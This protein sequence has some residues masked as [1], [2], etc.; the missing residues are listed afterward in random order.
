MDLFKANPVPPPV[1]PTGVNRSWDASIAAALFVALLLVFHGLAQDTTYGDG[2]PMLVVFAREGAYRVLWQHVLHFPVGFALRWLGVGDTAFESLRAVSVVSGAAGAALAYILF[3]A[4]RCSR[5]A[6]LG[7]SLLLALSPA[8]VFYSTTIEVHALHA[9][10]FAFAAC[11]VVLA[12]WQ[13][14]WLAAALSALALPL[15][16]LS[17]QSGPILGA[18]LLAMV[19]VGRERRG[20]SPLGWRALCLGIGPLYLAMLAGAFAWG[21]VLGGSTVTDQV[22]SNAAQVSF[23]HNHSEIETFAALWLE[24]FYVLVPLLLVACVSTRLGRWRSMAIGATLIPSLVYFTA[25][26][27]PERGGYA[28]PS[29]VVIAVGAAALIDRIPARRV[30]GLVAV[31]LVGVQFLASLAGIRSYKGPVWDDVTSVRTEVF[32]EALGERF[33]LYS[34]NFLFQPIDGPPDAREVNLYPDLLRAGVEG[35]PHERFA[36]E[37]V[38]RIAADV[39]AGAVERAGASV[40]LDLSY[41][42]ELLAARSEWIAYMDALMALL[43]E[44][45]WL[46]RTE[47]PRWPVVLIRVHRGTA[48]SGRDDSE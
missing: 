17:H 11:A 39:D 29:A 41:R 14:P 7:G 3:R 34:L 38:S 6:A 19:Q 10:C 9:A 2:A 1:T 21:A 18:G 28:L 32:R 30:A 42:R 5:A 24:P 16:S 45:F 23:F 33:V 27:V 4:W 13:R 43:E 26:G 36:H 37:I 25:W 48:E 15:V 40:G 44:R 31:L 8:W 20:L 47:H 22:I 46:Q 12:P 35:T